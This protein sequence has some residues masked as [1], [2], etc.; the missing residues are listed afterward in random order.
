MG[1]RDGGTCRLKCT[2]PGDF[3]GQ[4][5][6]QAARVIGVNLGVV[7]GARDGYVS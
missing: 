4:M 6:C 1:W 7:A 3:A 2:A 5:L